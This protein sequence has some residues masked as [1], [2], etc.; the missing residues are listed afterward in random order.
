MDNLFHLSAYLIA[1]L[2]KNYTN[3]ANEKITGEQL[4]EIAIMQVRKLQYMVG[5]M[6]VFLETEKNNRLMEFYDKRNGFKEFK[7]REKDGLIQM[8]KL[9]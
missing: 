7:T 4:M 2:G 1:Q 8:L 3:G 6:V 5:G 9:L